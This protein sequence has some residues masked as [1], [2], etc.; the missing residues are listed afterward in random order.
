MATDNIWPSVYRALPGIYPQERPEFCTRHAYHLFMLR[1]DAQEFA[2]PRA[3]VSEALR[4]EGIACSPGY[5]FSLPR[6]ADVSQTRVRPVS[7]AHL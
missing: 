1:L 2:A 7:A 4:A 3:A 6:A 5:G